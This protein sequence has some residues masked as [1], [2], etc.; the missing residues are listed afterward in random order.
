MS[1]SPLKIINSF[2]VTQQ[3]SNLPNTLPITHLYIQ[4]I[5]QYI[6]TMS[7]CASDI[8][9]FKSTLPPRKRAK[10]DEEKE[11][12]RVERIL[13]NRRAAHASREKKRRH[14]EYLESYV[15]KLEDNFCRALNNF[16]TVRNLVDPKQLACLKF[17]AIENLD[18]LKEAIH[19][20]ISVSPGHEEE[21]EE[22]PTPKKRK[23]HIKQ[24]EDLDAGVNYYNYMSPVS[25]NSPSNSPLDLTLNRT[26]KLESTNSDYDFMG[27]NS[28]VILLHDLLVYGCLINC[29]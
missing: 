23:T 18:E 13:R 9:S 21:E 12:R 22:I 29:S 26:V 8:S 1:G 27:Q 11:Q 20:N 14:V 25:I 16:A 19:S 3:T 10:T 6:H 15:L 28:E 24:E 2:I 17:D 7:D 5:P 4:A